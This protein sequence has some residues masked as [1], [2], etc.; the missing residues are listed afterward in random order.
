[1]SS[2]TSVLDVFRIRL[3]NDGR[4]GGYVSRL[5]YLNCRRYK[6]QPFIFQSFTKVVVW[7]KRLELACVQKS[8]NGVYWNKT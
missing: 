1:M 5:L 7:Q 6:L 8:G 4:G 3:A 2:K